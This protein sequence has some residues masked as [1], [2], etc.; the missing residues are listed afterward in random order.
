MIEGQTIC[1]G[2]LLWPEA[3]NVSCLFKFMVIF[4]ISEKT[5]T[6][7]SHGVHVSIS[8]SLTTTM[9]SVEQSVNQSEQGRQSNIRFADGF[10]AHQ[11]VINL[12]LLQTKQKRLYE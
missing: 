1:E 5:N 7:T 4:L 9:D 6:C 10:I 3:P 11:N 8:G 2:I 12:T